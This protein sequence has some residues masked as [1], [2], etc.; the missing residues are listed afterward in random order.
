MFI[1]IRTHGFPLTA[2]LREH[3]ERRLRFALA[4]TGEGIRSVTLT[5]GDIN[6]PRGG[7]DKTCSVR[8]ARHN[9]PVLVIGQTAEDMYAAID[10]AADRA[11][12]ALAREIGRDNRRVRR[13]AR[14]DPGNAGDL[15]SA[16]GT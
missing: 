13:P 3:A 9:R 1:E 6:G 15:V 8:I 2:S 10:R 4:R 11:G 5:L 12:R 14:P 7:C 16:A